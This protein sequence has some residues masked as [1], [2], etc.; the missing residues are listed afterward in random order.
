MSIEITDIVEQLIPNVLTVLAQLSATTI[1]FVLMYKLLWKPVQQILDTRSKYEQSRLIEADKLK[2]ENEKLNQQ[3]HQYID[4]AKKQAQETLLK[5]Q[6]EASQ[7]KNDLIEQGKQRSE[8]IV[9]EATNNMN[10]QKEKMLEDMHRQMVDVA[11]SATEK[12]LKTKVDSQTDIEQ[13]DSF[14]KEVEAK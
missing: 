9:E 1:L 13:I 2:D 14:V 8:Q 3:A 4:D 12:M 7:I 11:L 10:L 6:Q 5:A